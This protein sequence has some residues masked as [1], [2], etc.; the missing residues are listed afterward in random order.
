MRAGIHAVLRRVV[1]HFASPVARG[2]A[3]SATIF[4]LVIISACAKLAAPTPAPA[5]APVQPPPRVVGVLPLTGGA[6]V[7]GLGFAMAEIL[8]RDLALVPRVRVVER[9]RLDAVLKELGLAATGRLA[10]SSVPRAGQLIGAERL[11]NGV[12]TRSQTGASVDVSMLNVQTGVSELVYSERLAMNDMIDAGERLAERAFLR[13]GVTLSPAERER[14]AKRPT[15]RVDALIAFGNG[16][17]AEAMG[18]MP[19]ARQFYAQAARLDPAFVDGNG[20]LIAEPAPVVAA[21]PLPSPI[22]RA[23]LLAGRRPFDLLLDDL[24]LSVTDRVVRSV[25]PP[26]L[27]PPTCPALSGTAGTVI[28]R[29]TP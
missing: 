20:N 15:R 3:Q 13:L 16:R 8:S 21:V 11:L 10:A 14:L 12:V 26:A 6:G 24:M 28:V 4:A 23:P 18:N 1:R 22:V 9:A 2:A 27:C 19:A 29:I 25:S 5:P 7:E 17:R